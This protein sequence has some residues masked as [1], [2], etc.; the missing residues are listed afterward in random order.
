[1]ARTKPKEDR[2]IFLGGVYVRLIV[3][4]HW[5]GFDRYMLIGRGGEWAAGFN[6]Y[7][8]EG[9]PTGRTDVYELFGNPVQIDEK[10]IG[11]EHRDKF[12]RDMTVLKMTESDWRDEPGWEDEQ[13]D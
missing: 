13:P 9:D 10:G 2:E 12:L 7:P 5:A 3:T 11:V 4:S 1:M 8:F 6:V